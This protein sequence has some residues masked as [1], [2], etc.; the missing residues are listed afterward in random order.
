MRL[1]I[2]IGLG[3]ELEPRNVL[4][5]LSKGLGHGIVAGLR[6][7]FTEQILALF[8]R[9]CALRIVTPY[10][11]H[12]R[13]LRR[14]D[15]PRVLPQ[16]VH[17]RVHDHEVVEDLQAFHLSCRFQNL[18]VHVE[19]TDRAGTEPAGTS[20]TNTAGTPFRSSTSLQS[21]SCTVTL[22]S[23]V[24]SRLNAAS[25]RAVKVNEVKFGKGRSNPHCIDWASPAISSP[26]A[27]EIC[28]P[29]PA[30]ASTYRW[31]LIAGCLAR[32]VEH[33]E[34]LLDDVQFDFGPVSDLV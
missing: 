34:V 2:G 6:L 33:A 12:P 22:G 8:I 32:I 5:S 14:F 20:R 7:N 3:H 31:P 25:T 29:A 1:L 13:L 28:V 26:V 18:P 17:V 19:L 10:C 23:S 15:L 27:F 9:V 24:A 11:V 30:R 21:P 4:Q 16:D